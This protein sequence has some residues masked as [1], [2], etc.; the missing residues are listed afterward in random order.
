[1]STGV[2]CFVVSNLRDRLPQRTLVPNVAQ[3]A[4]NDQPRKGATT[5]NT[6]LEPLVPV[7][8]YRPTTERDLEGYL[9]AG[10]CSLTDKLT[11]YLPVS[12]RGY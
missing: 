9:S 7:M 6:Y 11:R 3:D 8:A 12:V 10:N 1:M 4:T 2:P 5:H